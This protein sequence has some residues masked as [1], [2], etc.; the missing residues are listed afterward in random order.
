MKTLFLSLFVHIFLNQS[1][2]MAQ[3]VNNHELIK[4][5]TYNQMINNERDTKNFLNDKGQFF[6]NSK[7]KTIQTSNNKDFKLLSV[8]GTINFPKSAQKGDEIFVYA[9]SNSTETINFIKIE[10][11]NVNIVKY[12]IDK[13][14]SANDYIVFIWSNKYRTQLFYNANNIENAIKVDTSDCNPDNEVNFTLSKGSSISGK[15]VNEHKIPLANIE[16]YAWSDKREIWKSATTDEHGNYIIE[17]LDP[18]DDYYINI[19]THQFDS[20]YYSSNSNYP[21]QNFSHAT[22]VNIEKN[23][24]YGFDIILKS[25]NKHLFGSINEKNNF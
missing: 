6:N 11:N 20:L 16:V 2:I 22:P 7:L 1:F 3:V 8:S 23:S 19:Y 21:V 5:I 10:Y 14:V 12:T 17:G 24:R 15:V 18:L 4:T 9:F 13:L 25:S